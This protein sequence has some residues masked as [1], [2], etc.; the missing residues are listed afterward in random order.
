[1]GGGG[2]SETILCVEILLAITAGAKFL[3]VAL[4]TFSKARRAQGH[5]GQTEFALMAGVDCRKS[6]AT[7]L[8]SSKL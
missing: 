4:V 6:L 2:A 3:E 7:V 8:M 1:M 5:N